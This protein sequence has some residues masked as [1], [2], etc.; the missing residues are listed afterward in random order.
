MR[1][2]R[3][4][5]VTAGLLAAVVA[6]CAGDAGKSAPPQPAA[7]PDVSGTWVY[8]G[9]P[10]GASLRPAEGFPLTPWAVE[11]MKSEKPRFSSHFR[12]TTDSRGWTPT[13][14]ATRESRSSDEGQTRADRRLVYHLWEYNQNW[15]QIARTRSTRQT[16][17]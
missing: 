8:P 1:A 15:R 11:K 7:R 2:Q 13:R 3:L 9:G 10:G 6:G 16:P 12:E 4:L 5:V 14:M 17:R